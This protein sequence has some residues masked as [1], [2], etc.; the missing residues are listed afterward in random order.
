M[1]NYL[2][3]ADPEREG[4][5]WKASVFDHQGLLGLNQAVNS[6]DW[7]FSGEQVHVN[8]MDGV[9][10]EYRDAL[11]TEM[12]NGGASFVWIAE[13]SEVIHLYGLA[14]TGKYYCESWSPLPGKG[15]E[16]LTVRDM[17]EVL[18]SAKAQHPHGAKPEG[19]KSHLKLI[20]QQ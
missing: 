14:T 20:E 10:A 3:V 4:E 6:Y 15:Y 16:L 11:S 18:A 7:A 8:A 9:T 5:W 12:L 19:G 2:L 1:L 17:D 13:P